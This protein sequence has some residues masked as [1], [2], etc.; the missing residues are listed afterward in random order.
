METEARQLVEFC[1]DL[2]E[3]ELQ[4]DSFRQNAECRMPYYHKVLRPS[5][6]TVVYLENGF[7]KNHQILHGSPHRPALQSTF[8]P[9]MTSQ[10]TS[11]RSYREKNCRNCRIRRLW[12]EFLANG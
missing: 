12:V 1:P 9:Y 3:P 4:T 10:A 6:E 8:K 11:G 5:F 7:T 2:R